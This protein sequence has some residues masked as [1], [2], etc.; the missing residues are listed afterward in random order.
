LRNR[1]IVAQRSNRALIMLVHR[2]INR[3]FIPRRLGRTRDRMAG[4]EAAT[5]KRR[6]DDRVIH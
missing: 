4:Q 3:H 5:S 6:R 1:N 2:T